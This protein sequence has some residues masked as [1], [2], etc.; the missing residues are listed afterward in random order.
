MRLE[1]ICIK[2]ESNLFGYDGAMQLLQIMQKEQAYFLVFAKQ[3]FANIPVLQVDACYECIWPVHKSDD[4]SLLV[5]NG[6]YV[7]SL[8]GK[9]GKLYLGGFTKFYETTRSLNLEWI[10]ERCV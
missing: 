5:R 10:G 6:G 1:L 3:N 2:Q 7:C 9:P 8:S 4:I